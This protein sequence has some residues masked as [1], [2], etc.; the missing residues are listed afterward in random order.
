M[1][2]NVCLVTRTINRYSSHVLWPR[3]CCVTVTDLAYVGVR[4]RGG[5]WSLYVFIS[6]EWGRHFVAVNYITQGRAN[7]PT[8][9]FP[10]RGNVSP[11]CLCNFLFSPQEGD[12]IFDRI[13]GNNRKCRWIATSALALPSCKLKAQC[14]FLKH[15]TIVTKMYLYEYLFV[16]LLFEEKCKCDF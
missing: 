13:V 15:S 1:A 8:G 10:L 5:L 2:W 7:K 9:T 11:V 3:S 16:Y 4:G 14:L 6:L 12:R